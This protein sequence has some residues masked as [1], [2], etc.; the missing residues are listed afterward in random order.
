MP[1]IGICPAPGVHA[2]GSMVVQSVVFPVGTA[3]YDAAAWLREHG[4]RSTLDLYRGHLRARQADP[5]CF[6][7]GTLRTIRFQR[8]GGIVAVVGKL[9]GR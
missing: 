9:R 1:T 7:S 4:Y 2:H 8:S 6:R 5:D 3:R